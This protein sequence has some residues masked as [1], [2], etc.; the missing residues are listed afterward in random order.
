M[1]YIFDISE[2]TKDILDFYKNNYNIAFEQYF[3]L[4]E[5]ARNRGLDKSKLNGYF[6]EHHIIPRSHNGSNEIY[7]LVLLTYKEHILAHMLLYCMDPNDKNLFLPFSLMV[8]LIDERMNKEEVLNLNLDAIVSIKESRSNFMKGNNNP[9]K[10]PKISKKVSEKKKGQ[11][12]WIKGKHHTEKTKQ[13]LREKTLSL[14][15]RGENHPMY[16]KHHTEEAKKIMSEKTKGE[17]HPLFGKHLKESTKKKLSEAHRN[18]VMG[19]DGTIYNSVKEAAKIVGINR[20]TIF[21]YLKNNPEKGWK[22]ISKD[23]K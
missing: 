11:T 1:Y 4:I 23:N 9:M 17:K 8:Q 18:P 10:D 20:T 2:I 21:N 15:F 14:G 7:N 12:P 6:E 13:I 3:E 22:R 16:G 5:E 19:P